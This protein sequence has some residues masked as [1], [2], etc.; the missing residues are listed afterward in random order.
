MLRLQTLEQSLT[1]N[2]NTFAKCTHA[3]KFKTQKQ[4]EILLT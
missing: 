3:N 4:L 2:K 1:T